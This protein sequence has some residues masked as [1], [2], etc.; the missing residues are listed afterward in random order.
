MALTELNEKTKL[1]ELCCRGH[2]FNLPN[3][4]AVQY[5]L[6]YV[7]NSK[8]IQCVVENNQKYRDEGHFAV[9]YQRQKDKINE[10]RRDNYQENKVDRREQMAR[11]YQTHKNRILQRQ[12]IYYLDVIKPNRQAKMNERKRIVNDKKVRSLSKAIDR[13]IQRAKTLIENRK[14]L[15]SKGGGTEV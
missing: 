8:C 11:Y 4:R 10:Q 15:S 6:Y 12:K 1:G 5:S 14:I 7:S 2:M 13:T 9:Y 3:G